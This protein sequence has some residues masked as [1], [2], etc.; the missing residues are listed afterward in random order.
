MKKDIK[1]KIKSNGFTKKEFLYYR[2]E[3]KNLKKVYNPNITKKMSL[4]DIIFGDA[5]DAFLNIK[6]YTGILLFFVFGSL[7][8]SA[9]KDALVYFFIIIPVIFLSVFFHAK[10]KGV[11]ARTELKLIKLYLRCLF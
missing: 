8:M 4:E 11:K 7:L 6:I 3:Y 5:K 2:G 10:N 1:G 9:G